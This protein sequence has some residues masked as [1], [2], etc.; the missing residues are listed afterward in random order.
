[1]PPHPTLLC[2]IL[3]RPIPT[4]PFCCILVLTH[5]AYLLLIQCILSRP[6]LYRSDPFAPDAMSPDP[7]RR[8]QSQSN[9]THPSHPNL[10]IL[11]HPC[12]NPLNASDPD[13]AHHIPTHPVPTRPIHSRSH[14]SDPI[15]TYRD[16]P[17]PS[18]PA[19]TG[20]RHCSTSSGPAR[21]MGTFSDPSAMAEAAPGSP[22][23]GPVGQHRP[24]PAP[25][26]APGAP[27]RAGPPLPSP[28]PTPSSRGW[29]GAGGDLGPSFGE[30]GVKGGTGG[31]HT[32][33]AAG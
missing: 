25:R 5:L 8:I 30:R 12:P 7:T 28:N 16:P 6:I 33:K 23:P 18:R 31:A 29:A 9:Q 10:P 19:L 21:A 1:M 2:P 13:P 17:V 14:S 32:P 22:A 20:G 24:G 4:H 26:T 27:P 15:A 3:I 11:P